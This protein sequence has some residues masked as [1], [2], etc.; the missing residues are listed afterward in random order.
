MLQFVIG[1]VFRLLGL[2]LRPFRLFVVLLPV[3]VWFLPTIVAHSSL[4]DWVVRSATTKINGTVT[5][6]GA[7]LGW[8][9]PIELRGVV[10]RDAA[11]TALAD[12]PKITSSRSLLALL[13]DS[14]NLG[15]FRCEKPT[16]NLVVSKDGTNLEKALAQYLKKN[17]VATPFASKRRG[18]NPDSSEGSLAVDFDSATIN[19][20]DAAT[21]EQWVLRLSANMRLA[22]EPMEVRVGGGTVIDHA[23]ITPPM[24]AGALGYAIPA[25]AGA[26]EAQGLVSV[27]LEPGTVNLSDMT[28]SELRGAV[29]LHSARVGAAPLLREFSGLFQAP[30]QASI[31]KETKVAFQITKGRVYHQNF[32]LAFPNF[33]VRTSGSVG[34]DGTVAMV[35]EMPVPPRWLGNNPL[36]TSLAKQAVRLPIG[37]TIDHPRLDAHALQTA[38]TQLLQNAAGGALRGEL[39]NNLKRLFGR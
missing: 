31:V 11:G 13:F 38:G 3:L 7:S 32:E 26:T 24:C 12:V 16:L 8:L 33:T 14:S 25:L 20:R 18:R 9:S 39:D 15:D 6:E 19:V 4:R 22:P 36:G 37:G 5:V 17:A 10:L 23:P 29:T 34:M 35:A 21:R 30:P 28:K 27:A 1:G 2:C